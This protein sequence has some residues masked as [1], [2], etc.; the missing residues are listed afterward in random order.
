VNTGSGRQRRRRRSSRRS[1]CAAG[2]SPPSDKSL[3]LALDAPLPRGP[4]P[5][6]AGRA[7]LTRIAT[8]IP[9]K[10]RDQVRAE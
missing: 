9:T 6:S 1:R 5:Q 2:G 8:A 10:T 3:L 7:D 4:F